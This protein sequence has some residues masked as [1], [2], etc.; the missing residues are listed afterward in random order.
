MNC[1]KPN[2]VTNLRR[3]LGASQYWWNLNVNF[4]FIASPLHALIVVNKV[5]R[6]EGKAHKYLD[7]LKEKIS[8][9]PIVALSD[10][11]Q[12]FDI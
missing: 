1:P 3:Y 8:I 12:P 9:A 6:W 2:N 7:T 10:I 5:F 11:Q 4:S